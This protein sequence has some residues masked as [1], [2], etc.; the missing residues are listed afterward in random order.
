VGIVEQ[1]IDCDDDND[2]EALDKNTYFTRL[3]TV[4]ELF[5]SQLPHLERPAAP[6]HVRIISS[7]F[8]KPSEDAPLLA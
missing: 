1:I 5:L 6:L 4:T 2:D 3:N 8:P 7:C